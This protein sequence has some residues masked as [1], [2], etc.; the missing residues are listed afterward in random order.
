MIEPEAMD[1]IHTEEQRHPVFRSS[2]VAVD[3]VV[4][5]RRLRAGRGEVTLLVEQREPV[6][7]FVTRDGREDRVSFPRPREPRVLVALVAIPVAARMAARLLS[8]RR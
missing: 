3:G 7:V 6:A 5:V 1:V 2:N 4:R 8:H